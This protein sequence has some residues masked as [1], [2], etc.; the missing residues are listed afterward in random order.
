MSLAKPNIFEKLENDFFLRRLHSLSGIVPIGVFTLF[1][2]SSNSIAIF[3]AENYTALIGVLRS[4]PFLELLEW[5]LIFLPLI[6]H[7]LYGIIIG[8]SSK[9]NHLQY[10][11]LENWR[12][13][14]QRATGMLALVYIIYH[15]LQLRY[16]EHLDHDY[17]AVALSGYIDI[18]YMPAIPFLNPLSVY[19]FYLIGLFSVIFHF[20]NGIWSFCITWGITIGKKSQQIMSVIATL[21]FLILMGMSV[22]TLNVLVERGHTLLGAT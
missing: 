6:F 7:A 17:V 4:L 12:Y 9:P 8:K 3:S 15:V 21:L 13:F 1:H 2:L 16:V 18:P 5:G 11:H 10:S 14:L 20:A 19:W 22:T